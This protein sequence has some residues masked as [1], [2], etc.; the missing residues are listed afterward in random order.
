MAGGRD[1]TLRPVPLKRFLASAVL[2]GGGELRA[3]AFVQSMLFSQLHRHLPLRF[4][5][6]A[7]WVCPKHT[8]PAA[9]HP[10]S[11]SRSL[12][13]GVVYHGEKLPEL[14]GAYIYGDHSTGRSTLAVVP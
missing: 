1:G 4:G 5:W 13:G 11:E 12:T 2:G 7:F 14:H 6:V 3:G 10:H 9:E 8:P